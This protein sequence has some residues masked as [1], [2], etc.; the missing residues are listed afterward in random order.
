MLWVGAVIVGTGICLLQLIPL[1]VTY[2]SFPT[3][4]KM[5]E[6]H[7]GTLFPGNIWIYKIRK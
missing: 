7:R 4:V 6:V 2:S 3:T 5:R 1:L